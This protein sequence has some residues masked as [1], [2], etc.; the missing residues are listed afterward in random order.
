MVVVTS[1]GNDGFEKEVS[2]PSSYNFD[3]VI[4]VAASNTSGTIASYSNYGTQTVDIVAQGGEY[5]APIDMLSFYNPKAN[6]LLL[7][8]EHPMLPL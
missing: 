8:R 7:K 4:T 5:S 1:A 2:Y 3:N 6:S